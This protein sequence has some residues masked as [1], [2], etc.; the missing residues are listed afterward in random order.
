[1]STW[2]F[3]MNKVRVLQGE[4]TVPPLNHDQVYIGLT[5]SH[6]DPGEL[7]YAEWSKVFTTHLDW[8]QPEEC[9]LGNA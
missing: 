9:N 4:V 6:G 7:H 1:M 8:K 5:A 3:T 2:Y